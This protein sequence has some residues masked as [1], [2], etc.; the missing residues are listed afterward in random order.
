[1]IDHSPKRNPIILWGAPH[2]Q[3]DPHGSHL[4]FIFWA[5]SQEYIGN[6][7]TC[8]SPFKE[9]P[10]CFVGLPDFQDS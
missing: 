7:R 4:E 10:Y 2:F 5:L 9:E 3:D 8:W 1:M 6:F